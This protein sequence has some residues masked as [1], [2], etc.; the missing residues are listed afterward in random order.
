MI[1]EKILDKLTE[2]THGDG[3]KWRELR[4]DSIE[5]A[6]IEQTYKEITTIITPKDP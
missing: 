1:K 2:M 6:F 4:D 5:K 3:A